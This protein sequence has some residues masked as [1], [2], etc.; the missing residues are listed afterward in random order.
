[1]KN[2]YV[3]K[4]SS[5]NQ[6][7]RSCASNITSPARSQNRVHLGCTARI[8]MTLRCTQEHGTICNFFKN[9]R[10]VT[11]YCSS[12]TITMIRLVLL[13]VPRIYSYHIRSGKLTVH[14][15]TNYFCSSRTFYCLY[16]LP[17][18]A[19]RYRNFDHRAVPDLSRFLSYLYS[20]TIRIV[21]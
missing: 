1:L 13:N 17:R 6:D 5:R 18:S 7:T 8:K 11:S 3:Y 12:I 10:T 15:I 9:K 2:I 19:L 4:S 20:H 16:H 14:K 21:A